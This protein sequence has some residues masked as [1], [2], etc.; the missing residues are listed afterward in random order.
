MGDQVGQYRDGVRILG[1][2]LCSGEKAFRVSDRK[3]K[4]VKWY[5]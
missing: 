5:E 4:V 1:G 3:G 2:S